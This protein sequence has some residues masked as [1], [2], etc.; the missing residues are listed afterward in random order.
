[1][2]L[3][4]YP[5]FFPKIQQK[6]TF[7]ILINYLKKSN[8]PN[9]FFLSFLNST[10]LVLR[11][12]QFSSQSVPLAAEIWGGGQISPPPP[13][14]WTQV[15]R[16]NPMGIV[17][18]PHVRHECVYGMGRFYIRVH[19]RGCWIQQLFDT[20]AHHRTLFGAPWR[21]P[22][23]IG[24]AMAFQRWVWANIQTFQCQYKMYAETEESSTHTFHFR[25]I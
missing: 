18:K 23:G 7:K 10:W 20:Q 22:R 11:L 19:I 13:P 1:M 15:T 6:S 25:M 17:L 8:G 5:N 9:F 16:N 4:E 12:C 21:V 2:I 24:C 14:Q 3:D